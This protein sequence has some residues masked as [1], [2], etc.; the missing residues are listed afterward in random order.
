[1]LEKNKALSVDPTC[2]YRCTSSAEVC[3]KHAWGADIL[4]PVVSGRITSKGFAFTYGIVTV[5]AKLP[6]GDWLYPGE[7]QLFL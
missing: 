1:M 7:K 6:Q 2:F 3:M 5:R 4:P